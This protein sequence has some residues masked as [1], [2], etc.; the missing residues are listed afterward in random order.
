M[1]RMISC[2]LLVLSPLALADAFPWDGVTT[3]TDKKMTLVKPSDADNARARQ[4]L[5]DV[6]LPSWVKRCG[7]RCGEV[8]N[9]HVAPLTGVKYK[10][11]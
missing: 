1:N 11:N 3:L 2:A 6:V 9:E 5:V 8:F 7:A 4:V 10:G